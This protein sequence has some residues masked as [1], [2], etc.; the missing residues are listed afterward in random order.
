MKTRIQALAEL[1]A[2]GEAYE[3]MEVEQYGVMVRAFKQAPETLRILFEEARSD[4]TF[5]VYEHERYSFEETWQMA[6][7]VATILGEE[8]DVVHGDRVAISMRNYPEWKFFCATHGN[9][10]QVAEVAA[11]L[12]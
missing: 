2:P 10:F 5:L 9:S 3:L 8:F 12:L 4:E 1:T 6:A 11:G 7:R